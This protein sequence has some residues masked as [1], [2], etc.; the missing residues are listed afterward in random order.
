MTF[1]AEGK[2]AIY[3]K[4]PHNSVR[5]SEN[6]NL[7]L[8]SNDGVSSAVEGTLYFYIAD[9]MSFLLPEEGT[10]DQNKRYVVDRKGNK[11]LGEVQA[12]VYHY[13]TIGDE[14]VSSWNWD[15]L[16]L[17]C[18]K[19][20]KV[21]YDHENHVLTFDNATLEWDE[22]GSDFN[23]LIYFRYAPKHPKSF[24]IRLI[25]DNYLNLN[26]TQVAIYPSE[27][28]LRIEGDGTLNIHSP[29]E[30][31]RPMVYITPHYPVTLACKEV[32]IVSESTNYN[33]IAFMGAVNSSIREDRKLIIDNTRLDITS[34]EYTFFEVDSII[35]K[36]VDIIEPEGAY[37]DY[38]AK[39]IKVGNE[40]VVPHVVFDVATYPVY[41]K[42]DTV[43][44]KNKDDVLGDGTVKYIP[45]KKQLILNNANISTSENVVCIQSEQE[46]FNIYLQGKNS[47][48]SENIALASSYTD[49]SG[50]YDELGL[51]TISG[52]GSLDVKSS[53]Y[54]IE[55]SAQ[56]LLLYN[57]G[58]VTVRAPYGVCGVISLLAYAFSTTP[59]K[60]AECLGILNSNLTVEALGE[61]SYPIVLYG[62]EFDKNS[63]EV[64]EPESW[65]FEF[66]FVYDTSTGTDVPAKRFVVKKK[67]KK[68]DVN[69]D[70]SVDINDVVAIINV[71]AGTANW[72]NAN[73]NDDSEGKVDINDVV[74]VINIMAGN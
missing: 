24:T 49:E 68:G 21:Y 11:Y 12:G 56:N 18:V 48:T 51:I 8:K 16:N 62:V 60:P 27:C 9:G 28:S 52:P 26:K 53:Q 19:K 54:G 14:K 29:A 73:V 35:T 20:G 70:G 47:L 6:C 3:T 17:S 10:Y 61:E 50:Q 1:R 22:E 40:K 23:V 36:K 72:P 15:H 30:A 65:K 39:K 33:N 32:K 58:D 41:V 63:V 71:M 2:Q 55:F 25:G 45:E 44:W 38:D 59:A 43:T 13:L 64:V 37:F 46:E 66:P 7:W 74:V 31:Y 69:L 34:P 4:S 42:G 5:V 67:L 57:C